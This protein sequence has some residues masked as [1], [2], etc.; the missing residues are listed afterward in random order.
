MR[1]L[2][3]F[4]IESNLIEGIHRDPT[5]IELGRAEAFLSLPT[6]ELKNLTFLQHA[7]AP[8]K[9]LR[10][11]SGMNV[12]VGSYIAPKGGPNIVELI[13]RLLLVA[14]I[15]DSDP[16]VTHCMFEQIH[17]FIDGNGRTGRML[18]AWQMLRN[19][20]DPFA[21]PFLHRFYYQTLSSIS[22]SH[23]M[24]GLSAMEAQ[25]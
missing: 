13:E 21:L 3:S 10:N 22:I 15:K 7:F 19:G 25:R 12:R 6:I 14:H 1:G 16:W 5:G 4:L 17:P 8:G 20:N 2:N 9:P 23:P 18:W 11:K 24:P